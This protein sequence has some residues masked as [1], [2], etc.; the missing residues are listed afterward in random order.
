MLRKLTLACGIGASLLYVIMNV[1]GAMQYPGYSTMS[2]SVSELSAIGAPSR[3]L[4]VALG[5]VY[6]VLVIAFG[7][8]VWISAGRN[9]ALRVVGGLLVA[10]GLTGFAWP[11]MH[12]RGDAF[13]TS[14]VMHIVF[15]VVWV[16]LSLLIIGFGAA[17]FG[18]RFRLYSIA[19]LLAH[20]GFGILAGIS[21]PRIA[22]GLPTPWV[23]LVERINIGA[24]LL[25]V[26]VL[27]VVLLRT[28]AAPAIV[29][30]V[31]VRHGGAAAQ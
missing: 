18:K 12:P 26:V 10:S 4:W 20:L 30:M 16:L 23:G 27:A 5:I 9:R 13:S 15:T 2:Q 28:R 21:G 24:F 29:P 25:W 22:A 19:T 7:C 8:G 6:G 1:V 31:R 17:A 14:D 3:P 11:P